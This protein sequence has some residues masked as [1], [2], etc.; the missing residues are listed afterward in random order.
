LVSTVG[1]FELLRSAQAIYN[2]N[3]KTIP[4]L[5]VAVIWYLAMTSI[6]QIG[7]FYL[8]RHYGRGSTRTTALTPVQR[9]KLILS[10]V[11]NRRGPFG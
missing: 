4:L 1:I 9:A 3:Y 5:I 7:Q 10:S 8:E 2:A 11:Q 6:L